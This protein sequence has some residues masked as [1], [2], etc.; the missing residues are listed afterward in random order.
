[1]CMAMTEPKLIF[2]TISEINNH[3]QQRIQTS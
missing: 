2:S 1:M 3:E